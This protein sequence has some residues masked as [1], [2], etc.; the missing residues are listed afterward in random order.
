MELP[1]I[2]ETKGGRLMLQGM[3]LEGPEGSQ[4]AEHLAMLR[5]PSHQPRGCRGMS[6]VPVPVQGCHM[7]PPGPGGGIGSR[8]SSRKFAVAPCSSE[9]AVESCTVHLWLRVHADCPRLLY[10][11]K[12]FS[13]MS[14]AALSPSKIS[15]PCTG[16]AYLEAVTLRRGPLRRFCKASAAFVAQKLAR[17]GGA[18]AVV[19]FV[20]AGGSVDAARRAAANTLRDVWRAGGRGKYFATSPLLPDEGCGHGELEVIVSFWKR[21]GQL[22]KYMR[23]APSTDWQDRRYP[24]E[25]GPPPEPGA[26]AKM[27]RWSKVQEAVWD[28]SQVL[29]NCSSGASFHLDARPLPRFLG[30]APEPREN[31]RLGHAPRSLSLPAG[32]VLK[33][34]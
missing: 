22:M 15:P 9:C 11:L 3:L 2:S 25:E 30:E 14:L 26:P 23:N 13:A 8:I 20:S 21:P 27:A 31:M 10:A 17:L 7:V 34:T 24:L 29:A 12:S 4:E 6:W 32:S 33:G 19:H 5:F 28:K 1:S 18:V 16:P